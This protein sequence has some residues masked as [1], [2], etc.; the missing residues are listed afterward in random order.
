M[1]TTHCQRIDR[2]LQMR[3]ICVYKE[4]AI[5]RLILFLYAAA[6]LALAPIANAMIGQTPDQIIRHAQRDKD[7]VK[8]R[9]GE[10]GGRPN[11]AVLYRDGTI[12]SHIIGA[13]GY[14]I[15]FFLKAPKRLTSN[16]VAALQRQYHTTWLGKGNEGGFFE[17]ESTSGLYMAAMR[18]E[19]TDFL[20]ILSPSSIKEITLP[21]KPY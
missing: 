14:E 8:V 20:V 9:T 13:S 5:K 11:L 10:Y 16:D 17:W 4:E 19:D 6:L 21:F 7:I 3:H 18:L 12:M 15:A 2:G 1:N